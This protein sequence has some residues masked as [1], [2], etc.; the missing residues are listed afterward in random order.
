MKITNDAGSPVSSLAGRV[1]LVTGASGSIGAAASRALADRGAA[2][3]LHGRNTA[4]LDGAVA[5]IRKSGGQAIA[6][7]GDVRDADHLGH[8]VAET[9]ALFG[10]ID[11]LVALAGGDGSPTPSASLT[12]ARWREVIETDLTSAFLTVHA[13]LPD[14]LTKGRGVIVTTSSSA[15]R[16]PSQANAAY[17]AAKAGVVMLT[18]HL[19]A[20]YAGAGIRVNCVA[21]SIIE[22]AKLRQR[23]PS[24]QL[25]A[26]AEHVPLRRIGQPSDVVDAIMFLVSDAATWITG[27]VLD[28]TGGMTL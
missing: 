16:R 11:I 8:V 1:A 20:E 6:Y 25:T 13:V 9:R 3:A 22:T 7:S 4:A 5:A 2:V 23:V 18:Q 12:A 27:T 21:P 15:G 26:I 24:E 19:A 28:V 14:M 10:G 17:A